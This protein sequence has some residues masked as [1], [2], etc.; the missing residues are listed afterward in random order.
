MNAV[1]FSSERQDWETPQAL[2]DALNA[3]FGFTLDV[4]ATSENKKCPDFID[5]ELNA[6]TRNWGG[7]LETCWMNPPYGYQIGKWIRKAYEESQNGATVVALIPAKTETRWWHEYVMHAHE[8]RLVK[9]R[10]QFSGCG[11]N[12]PFPSAVVV[13]RRGNHVPGFSAMEQPN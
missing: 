1:H 4:C 11:V 9:G 2:F 13:F 6:L 3:E 10:I 8:I 12:A 5:E 7:Y